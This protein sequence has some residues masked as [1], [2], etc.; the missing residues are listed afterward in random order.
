MAPAP[1]Q[2]SIAVFGRSRGRGG[3]GSWSG[4]EEG[5]AGGEE[6]IHTSLDLLQPVAWHP[7]SFC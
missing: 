6:G 7:A 5:G 4:W 3:G 1:K 2:Q